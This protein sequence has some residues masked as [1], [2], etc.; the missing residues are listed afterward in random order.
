M[1]TSSILNKEDVNIETVKEEIVENKPIEP[2]SA[3]HVE[4]YFQPRQKDTLFWCFYLIHYGTKAYH[5]IGHNYGVKEM[6]EK[7]NIS[8]YVKEHMPK[9]KGTN[10]KVTNGMLQ[11]IMSELVTIQPT[12]SMNVLLA[13]IVYYHVNILIVEETG[14][15]MLAFWSDKDRIP[16]IDR[17]TDSEDALT[18]VLHKD[19]YG[20]YKVQLEPVSPSTILQMQQQMVTLDSY[21]RALKSITHYAVPDLIEL[22]KKLSCY[23]ETKKYK[24][25]ELY[26]EIAKQC[27]WK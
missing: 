9:I 5:D 27:V 11:E 23:D 4:G 10:Y 17:P 20:K 6:E 7:H 12:T 8:K 13:M 25:A 2:I 22:A 14:K 26:N 1:L 3:M 24:K 19:A 21:H 15:C 18:Y 16:S